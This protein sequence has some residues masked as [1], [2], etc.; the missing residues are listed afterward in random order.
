MA[1]EIFLSKIAD[2]RVEDPTDAIVRLSATCVCASDLW[3][4][5]GIEAVDGRHRS[6]TSFTI[7]SGASL[8]GAQALGV[9]PWR[10]SQLIRACRL[11]PARRVE[12]S[13][14]TAQSVTRPAI[15]ELP[16]QN[17]HSCGR[18]RLS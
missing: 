11:S 2:P 5:R 14:P 18:Q 4:Y 3:P 13:E 7:G 8:R 15:A 12:S 9:L 6:A 10:S 17:N 16:I 1:L